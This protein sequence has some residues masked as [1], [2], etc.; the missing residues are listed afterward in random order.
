MD[1]HSKRSRHNK[2]SKQPRKL[3]PIISG[4]LPPIYP[5]GSDSLA[6][7]SSGS[8]DPDRLNNIIDDITSE[9]D[10]A[11]AGPPSKLII[12]SPRSNLVEPESPPVIDNHSSLHTLP[13]SIDLCRDQL[14][15]STAR[16][17]RTK[18]G[19]D[20]KLQQLRDQKHFSPNRNSGHFYDDRTD[21]SN[22]RRSIGDLRRQE[23]T[24]TME[25]YRN[26]L[27]SAQNSCNINMNDDPTN[28]DRRKQYMTAIWL[29]LKRY[30]NGVNPSDENGIETERRL[31]EHQRRQALDEFHSEFL[32]C[33]FEG[34][35]HPQ[36]DPVIKRYLLS[37]MHLNYC[38]HVDQSL[39]I[40][41]SKWDHILSLFPSSIAL[42][43]YDKRFDSKTQ[44]GQMFYE[45]LTVF[46]AW[47]N[48]NSEINRLIS[49]LGRIMAC[50]SCEEWPNVPVSS[51]IRQQHD[52]TTKSPSRPPTPSSTTSG[53]DSR[54]T[55]A[56]SPSNSSYYLATTNQIQ[57]KQ[58]YSSSSSRISTPD[59][60]IKR[61]HTIASIPSMDN[62]HQYLTP[63]S[64]LTE[65]Y[66]RYIDDQL[67]HARIELI[68][69]IFRLKH[70]PLLQRLR[71]T[72]RKDQT[73]STTATIDS[74]YKN[75]PLLPMNLVP[76]D[77]LID[78]KPDKLIDEFL[79]LHK[80]L[81]QLKNPN[82]GRTR[83]ISYFNVSIFPIFSIS[84]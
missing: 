10:E 35:Y 54:D 32:Q 66:Y 1:V 24:N 51:I 59:I 64:L 19:K 15:S 76:Q 50:T 7:L 69:S 58:Q 2:S 33:D 29:E 82:L 56:S 40:L 84:K 57:L 30:F 4:E 83:R 9:T 77:Y 5:R 12:K 62:I 31:I 79:T 41:F 39:R 28:V 60:T 73:T 74:V 55:F 72:L 37:E 22:R 43:Q 61:Q 21:S 68:A 48:L 45:K 49:V 6:N 11:R 70:G 78:A 81:Q 3:R 36:D 52:S 27:E 71:Y 67:T 46:Q 14:I 47:F 75:H 8:G 18:K 20:K 17:A 38:N 44:K 34:S 42:E 65:Y 53:G 80:Q 23:L 63:T 13:K 25:Y 26:C 16:S